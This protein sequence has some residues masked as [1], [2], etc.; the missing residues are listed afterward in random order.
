ML[1]IMANTSP[2]HQCPA[3]PW[4]PDARILVSQAHP[5]CRNAQTGESLLLFVFLLY[6]DASGH[7][8]Q[9]S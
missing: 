8:R 9:L 3:V 2:F 6:C 4:P 7:L 5:T 1:I